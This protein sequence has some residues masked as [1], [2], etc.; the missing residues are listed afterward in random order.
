M[1]AILPAAP[2]LREFLV[3]RPLSE[4]RDRM[5]RQ[6]TLLA[7]ALVAAL[8]AA[9]AAAAERAQKASSAAKRAAPKPVTPASA[10]DVARPR[11]PEWFGLYLMGKKAGWTRTSLGFELKDGKRRFVGHA[12]ATI[13]ATVGDRTV[14]RS[15]VDEK[16]WEA[17][18]GGRLV[19]FSSRHQ[20]DGGDRLVEGRC[21]NGSCKVTITAEGKT[22]E[23]TLDVRE[24]VED[25]DAARLAAA[26]RGEVRGEQL[27]LESL[28]VRKMVDRYTGT[29]KAAAGGV[30]ATL[31]V[32]D[33]LE[34]GD[35]A[36]T[37]FT[38]APDGRIVEMKLGDAIVARAEPEETARR[39]DKVDLFAMTR[40]ALPGPLPRDVPGTLVLRLHGVPK[41][42]EVQDPRQTWERE[43][44]GTTLLTVAARRPA[45]ADPANDAPRAPGVKKGDE[46]LEATPDVDADAPAIRSL[47]VKEVGDARGV[48]AASV[49]LVHFVYH[50]LEKAYG[51]SRDRATEVLALGKG[52]CTEHAL[53]FTALA[54]AAGIPARQVHGL[55]FA[56]YDDDVPALYWH[57]WVEVKSGDEWIAVDP[58]FDQPVADPTHVALGR[59]TQVDTVGLLGA[60]QV[61]SAETRPLR[62]AVDGA[63]RAR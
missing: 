27:E 49:K 57:A 60:I 37:R 58:T 13:S 23:R 15:E 25:A 17:R 31:A 44:D 61:V 24:T 48:Y 50:R 20:G 43:P 39:L 9:P 34:E 8:A 11:G 5:R 19:S 29:T 47:A 10:L 36:A 3:E 28:R 7:A 22:E 26:R 38:I 52:D 32:V 54:R 62:A 42:F 51:V 30:E 1:R 53:L 63:P 12:E 2:P 16:V 4:Q 18:R 55:V 40:V 35:R 45:A 59:G 46:L 33:E 6:T 21:S 14:Q 56:R 41:E